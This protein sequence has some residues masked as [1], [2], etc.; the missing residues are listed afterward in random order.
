L[1]TEYKEDKF[2]KTV[3][4]RKTNEP[5]MNST[6][7]IA[8]NVVEDIKSDKCKNEDIQRTK[9]RKGEFLK[10]KKKK[11]EVKHR[12]CIRNTD[13]QIISEDIT[14]VWIW[15]KDLKAET[16][17]ELMATQDQVLQT[18]YHATKILQKAT[19]G[20]CQQ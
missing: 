8:A 4:N 17:S 14:F 9:A 11:W 16:E 15:W 3:K 20:K 5:N 18:K 12:H 1:N 13:R 7:L 6:I 10:E 2:V 19:E